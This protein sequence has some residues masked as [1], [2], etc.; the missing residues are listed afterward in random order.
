[1][2]AHNVEF[3]IWE[4]ITENTK[5][6]PKKWYLGHLTQKLKKFELEN[7]NSYDYLISVSERDL[8]L[9]KKLGYKNGAMASPIG[10]DLNN[11]KALQTQE[12]GISFI[13]ALDWMPNLEGLEWF[14]Q[15]VWPILSQRLPNV[16]FHIAGRN[17]PDHIKNL[18]VKNVE[19]HGEVP[20][21][22]KFIDRYPVMVV[23]LFSGSGMRV[24]ILEGMALSK[25]IVSTTL[26][27]EGIGVRDQEEILIADE[28]DTFC[29][30]IV[31]AFE[32]YQDD[33]KLGKRAYE[34][35]LNYYDHD[36]LAEKLL[37]KYQ[38][39]IDNPYPKEL[40]VV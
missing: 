5:F 25:I 29:D 28:A 38:N 14:L 21:A 33:N 1:M 7:L 32:L 37:A 11:Y 3:E 18:N 16:K 6:L 9:F 26:G 19:V 40:T 2:R 4:R 39:L 35:V 34:F 36:V 31:D 22:I 15:K 10:L 30:K 20:D 13:G 27:A 8:K 23:P 17:T 12:L 24:K